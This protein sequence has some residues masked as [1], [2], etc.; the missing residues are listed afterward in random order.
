MPFEVENKFRVADPAELR[1][2]I[3]SLG[4]KFC[5]SETH[6]DSYFNHPSRDFRQTD[7]ALRIRDANGEICL[8]FKGPR[9]NSGIKMRE[10]IELP[11]GPSPDAEQSAITILNRLGFRFVACVKKRRDVY[12]LSKE[13]WSI[14]VCMD[15][16]DQLGTFAEI[17][18]VAEAADLEQAKQL[19]IDLQR[20]LHLGEPESRSYL[21]MQLA[22]NSSCPPESS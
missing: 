21:K 17:E 20:E 4:A 19:V 11:L 14:E 9:F 1:R 22:A 13:R 15:D 2:R 18:L 5:G 12:H 8:T 16:V 3:E 10:E 6:S 7:E